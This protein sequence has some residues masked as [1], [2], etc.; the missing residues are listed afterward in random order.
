M[1]DAQ[2]GVPFLLNYCFYYTIRSIR[3]SADYGSGGLGFESLWVRHFYFD[4]IEPVELGNG[5][6]EESNAYRFDRSVAE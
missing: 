4:G 1:P 3:K 2:S 6:W 5:I